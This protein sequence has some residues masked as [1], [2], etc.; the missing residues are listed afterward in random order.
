VGIFWA[1]LVFIKTT[2]GPVG[3]AVTGARSSVSSGTLER[4][5]FRAVRSALSAINTLTV[6]IAFQRHLTFVG[7]RPVE[8]DF[9]ADG[10]FVFADG[11][12]NGGF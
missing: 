4:A 11:H 8:L 6:I 9:F 2:F 10:G 7:K 3:T 12:C 5:V 1:V